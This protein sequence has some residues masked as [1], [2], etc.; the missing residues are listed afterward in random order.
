MKNENTFPKNS[1][2]NNLQKVKEMVYDKC[3]FAMS[4]LILNPE[5][6]D[7]AAC[8]F[9][10]NGKTI[11]HRVSKITPTKTGQFVA[12]W[13]RNKDACLCHQDRE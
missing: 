1:I 7:Y 9:E 13:K 11:Q 12:I 10:L 4:N 2:H 5:S 6:S 8:S 3:G